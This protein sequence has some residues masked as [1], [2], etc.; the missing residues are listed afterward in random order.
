MI[1]NGDIYLIDFGLSTFYVDENGEPTKIKIFDKLYKRV[2]R[3]LFVISPDNMAD[4]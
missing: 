4:S 3:L 2:S 1:K